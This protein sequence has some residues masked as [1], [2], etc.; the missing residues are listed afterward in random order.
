MTARVLVTGS[1]TWDDVWVIREALE[2]AARLYGDFILVSGACPTGADRIAEN[3]WYELAGVDRVEQHPADWER[4]GNRAGFLR[5][6]E[7]VNLGAD[8]C[9]AFVKNNSR[10]ALMTI[11]M[12]EKAGIP[13]WYYTS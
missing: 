9:L 10:G 3:I 5:N 13:V 2:N 4:Y 11:N 12:A 7:M 1:R 6:E 8:L